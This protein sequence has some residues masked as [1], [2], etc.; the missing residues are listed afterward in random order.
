MRLLLPLLFITSRKVTLALLF[1]TVVCT[2]VRAQNVQDLLQAGPML[3]H[4]DFR[5]VK[6]WVQ[7]TAPAE[8][9]ID[10]T[11]GS[12]KTFSTAP[13]RTEKRTAYTAH[14]VCDEVTPGEKYTYRLRINDRPVKLNYPTEF[15]VQ[16]LWRFRN[17]PPDFSVALGSCTYVNDPEYDRPGRAYGG[18]YAIFEAI[19]ADRPDLMLWLG[20]NAYLRP[21]DWGSRT[22]Y[23]HRFTHSR[24]VP[25][26]QPLLARTHHYGV[27]DDH[28]YG[29]NDS[30]RSWIHRELAKETFDLFWANPTSGLPQSELV[31]GTRG[32]TTM[33]RHVDT[34]FFLLDNRSFRTPNDQEDIDHP[35][36]LGTAQLEW[37]I[38][39]LIFSDSPHKM[40]VLGGQVLTD[41]NCF[42]TYLALAPAEREYLLRRIDEEDIEGVVFVNGDR[43]HS[44][45]STLVLPGG[46]RVWDITIS[47]LTSGAAGSEEERNIFR[48]PGTFVSDRNYGILRYSGPRKERKLT[49]SV[50]DSGGE[51]LWE[52]EL[53]R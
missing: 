20:D 12:G 43:H 4:N 33:F 16:P 50:Y 45:L 53:G 7:T 11:D 19:H 34:D 28:D 1:L 27:W 6:I 37:L 14:L 3:G 31:Y 52:R 41:C 10:Y 35:T 38:E 5:E 13:V 32:I 48:V 46:N 26:M 24:S 21:G 18:E 36:V 15:S 8:V 51:L 25:E 9:V 17:D 49:V 22:G 44:E 47:P 40:V 42:E 29:P 39:A 2:C 30:D 23:H